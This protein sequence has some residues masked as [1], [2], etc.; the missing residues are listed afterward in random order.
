[1][2]LSRIKR[3][4]GPSPTCY[5]IAEIGVNH[6][7]DLDVARRLIDLAADTGCD[8]VK[9]QKRTLEL[10]YP[11]EVLDAPRESPWGTTQRDQKE[12]LELG[13]AEYDQIDAHCRERGI[14][15]FA[16]AWDAPSFE[17]LASYNP[18]HSKIAS[19][20]LTHW[21][22]LEQ[23]A[24]FGVHTFI[25]TGMSGWDEVDRAV[26]IFRGAGCPFTLMQS[27]ATYPMR[28]EDANIAVML[29]LARRYEVPV[30]F[31]SHEVGLICSVTAAALGAVAIERHITLDRA[32]YGSDQAASL[33]KPG[34][35]RLVRDVRLLPS[36]YGVGEKRMLDAEEPI[37]RKLRYFI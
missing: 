7:G 30:G 10:V 36:I 9:F 1:M 26:E 8:A 23:V 24:A 14:D 20:M 32:M 31:S 15:W 2:F 5:I 11:P 18:P 13:R 35:E 16:S 37:A 6:N 29:E 12:A 27:V 33:E 3:A 28:N 17:F 34:L 22:F 21:E 19:A 4:N 25:S